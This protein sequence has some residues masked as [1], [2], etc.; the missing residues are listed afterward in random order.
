MVLSRVLSRCTF[1][2]LNLSGAFPVAYDRETET[3][4]VGRLGLLAA[5]VQVALVGLEI[6]DRAATVYLGAVKKTAAVSAIAAAARASGLLAVLLR[7]IAYA[8]RTAA[9]YDELRTAW[10]AAADRAAREPF[11]WILYAGAASVFVDF[12]GDN[13]KRYVPLLSSSLPPLLSPPL[14]PYKSKRRGH[15]LHL[16]NVDC[17]MYGVG[18]GGVC[19]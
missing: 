15:G 17:S 2:L 9:R 14:R 1:V 12:A 5:F 11:Q 19:G 16:R 7:R 18:G 4:T 13:I 10:P 8:G 3:F 6:R